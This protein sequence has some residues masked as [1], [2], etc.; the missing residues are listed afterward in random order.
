MLSKVNKNEHILFFKSQK[1]WLNTPAAL[2]YR[3]PAHTQHKHTDKPICIHTQHL[4]SQSQSQKS[5]T[6]VSKE[7]YYSVKGALLLCQSLM[8]WNTGTHNFDV[9]I[10]QLLVVLLG[11]RSYNDRA[12]YHEPPVTPLTQISEFVGHKPPFTPLTQI[13]EF[14]G[15]GKT[16]PG[17]RLDVHGTINATQLRVN[18]VFTGGQWTTSEGNIIYYNS[19]IIMYN[20]SIIKLVM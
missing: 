13:S 18:G 9:N 3:T 11:V 1:N 14:V 6:I 10:P 16:D 17:Y 4:V 5:P 15:I 2:S 7:H 8:P 19:N 20:R 12:I